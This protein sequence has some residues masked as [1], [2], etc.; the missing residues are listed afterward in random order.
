[1]KKSYVE[2]DEIKLSVITCRTNNVNETDPQKA[3]ISSC[4][5][6][7]F[8]NNIADKFTHRVNADRTLCCYTDYE[9]DHTGNYTYAIGEEV[10]SF[11]G[12]LDIFTT[13]IIPPQM[14]VKFTIGPG[15]MPDV[16]VNAWQEIWKMEDK[17]FGGKRS[18]YTDFEVYDERASDHRNVTLDIYIG[19]KGKLDR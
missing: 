4:V 7:Y 2:L 13:L 16:L 14:Y 6:N 10:G 18:Y 15:S 5:Q 9:N 8:H 11:E 19:L 17:D 1:M 3:K 12:A